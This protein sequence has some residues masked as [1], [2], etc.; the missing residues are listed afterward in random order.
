MK[1]SL[2]GVYTYATM[3][4]V[5]TSILLVAISHSSDFISVIKASCVNS[6]CVDL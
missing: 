4:E 3:L 2:K 1:Y 5:F 6:G